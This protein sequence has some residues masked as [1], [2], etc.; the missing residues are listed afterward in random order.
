MKDL[1][2]MHMQTREFGALQVFYFLSFLKS[3]LLVI[4]LLSNITLLT[5]CSLI[6]IS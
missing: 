1:I 5:I 6:S 3:N 2:G 4:L